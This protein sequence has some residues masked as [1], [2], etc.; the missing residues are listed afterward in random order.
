MDNLNLTQSTLA[1]LKKFNNQVKAAENGVR[2]IFSDSS[3]A[4]K[5][6]TEIWLHNN[7]YLNINKVDLSSVVSK[8]IGETEKNLNLLF[9]KSDSGNVTLFFDEAD[10]L[11]GKRSEVSD[12]HDRYANIETSFLLERLERYKGVLILSTNSRDQ[13]DPA[14][15]QLMDLTVEI[16]T[17]PRP[18]S[19]WQRVRVWLGSLFK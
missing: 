16:K 11:F 12:S 15:L 8:Y 6:L 2:A 13:I 18:V 7:T 3:G 9:D 4:G 1:Q 10:A 5:T 19:I 14:I 17:C